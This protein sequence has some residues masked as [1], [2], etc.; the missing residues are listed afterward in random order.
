MMYICLV[1]ALAA[2]SVSDIKKRL[3]PNRTEAAMIMMRLAFL[4]YSASPVKQA[5]FM[6]CSG[7]MCSLVFLVPYLLPSCTAGAGDV[8][9]FFAAGLYYT[10]MTCMPFLFLSLFS[11]AVFSAVAVILK[12]AGMKDTLPFAP[13]ALFGA[14]ADIIIKTFTGV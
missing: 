12:K 8:K 11:G 9:L 7:I 3:I 4:I 6:L 14:C 1:T 13:F 5:F 2:A 10:P